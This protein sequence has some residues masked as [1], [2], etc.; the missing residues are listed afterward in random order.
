MQ[1]SDLPSPE[2]KPDGPQLD[3]AE[4]ARLIQ[5]DSGVR[6]ALARIC[7][8]RKDILGWGKYLFPVKFYLPFCPNLHNYLISIRHEPLTGTEAPRNH[9][10]TLIR[11]FLTEIFQAL[12]EPGTFQHY[13]NVQDTK[14][15]AL[16]INTSIRHE[17]E[18]NEELKEIYGDQVGQD[19]WTDTQ[20][21]L[22]NGT[23]FTAVSTGQSIRGINY[24][25]IRPD[26]IVPD[27]LFSDEDINNPDSTI[28]KNEWFWGSLYP[29]RAKSRR[30]C[31]HVQGTAINNYDTLKYISALKDW[32]F[33][34]FKAITDWENKVVLWP[35][36]NTFDDLMRDMEFMGTLIFMR[37]MQNERADESESK[38]KSV[39]LSDWEYDP[40][41]LVFDSHNLL[42]DVTLA[43]DPSIGEKHENDDTAMAL[44]YKARHA[45]A[46]ADHFYCHGL[47]N[48][49]LSMDA[50]IR[51]IQRIADEQP[52]D[53]RIRRVNI[54]AI[55]GFKDFGAEV[56]RR[57]NLAVNLIDHVPDK[58]THLENKSSIFETRKF[59]L[60]KLIDTRLK[61]LLKA[62][63]TTNHPAHDDLRDAVLHGLE[64]KGGLWGF[65]K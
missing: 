61:N 9:A 42:L 18:T 57:T 3:D 28:K 48:E 40:S 65:V 32:K 11:D 43:V 22:R 62:Q 47:W 50:R 6:I 24:N 53:R 64:K 51:L 37:E 14:D 7:A 8:K 20:F 4:I 25:N 23:I 5:L 41:Q 49:K 63:L 60:N 38:V 34:T 56:R 55:A 17:L 46:R 39:W 2:T 13:L 33:K 54:E 36:L 44:I 27:D 19:K 59:F 52:Q 35:E 16:L 29:A 58:L 15:K 10:K 1:S 30:N 21:V 26:Y 45:D 12:E 31:V